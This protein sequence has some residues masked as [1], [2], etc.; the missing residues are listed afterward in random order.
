M[1]SDVMDQRNMDDMR[2]RE[3]F[4]RMLKEMQSYESATV[5]DLVIERMEKIVTGSLAQKDKLIMAQTMGDM[6]LRK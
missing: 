6:Q 2:K 5:S 3:V 1:L 4:S